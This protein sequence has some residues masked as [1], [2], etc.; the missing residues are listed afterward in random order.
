MK[1]GP[2]LI[3]EISKYPTLEQ[4]LDRDP[5]AIPYTDV[6]LMQLVKTERLERSLANIKNDDKKSK[7]KEKQDD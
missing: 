5:H 6:E 7:R 1:T 2:E 4:F 3:E